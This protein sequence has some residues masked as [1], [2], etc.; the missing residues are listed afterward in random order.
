MSDGRRVTQAECEAFLAGFALALNASMLAASGAIALA[1]DVAADAEE[2]LLEGAEPH[3]LWAERVRSR[4]ELAASTVS[5]VE[6]LYEHGAVDAMAYWVS[7]E[8]DRG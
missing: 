6:R 3:A 7:G 4:N 2:A 5:E 8:D 1:E